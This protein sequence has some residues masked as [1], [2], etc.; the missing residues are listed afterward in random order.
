MLIKISKKIF[1]FI[2]I[3]ILMS[4]MISF[5]V[6]ALSIEVI[7]ADTDP[8]ATV[9]A[10]INTAIATGATT[11]TVTGSKITANS[12][13]NL[14]IPAGVT[15]VWNAVYKGTAN[16]VIDYYGEGTL[17]IS[18]PGGWV[19]NTSAPNSYSAIRANGS[20]IV[21]SGGIVQSGKGRAIEGAGPNTVVSVTGGSVFNEATSNLFPVIDMTNA[22]NI[23]KV[24]VNVSGGEV[25]A[26]SA[27]STA[28]G[29]VIQSYGNIAISG[30]KLSTSGGY[31]RVINLVGD[32]TNVTVSGGVLEA[33]GVAGTAISTST[34]APTQ[35]T[36][37]TVTIT[38]GFVAS[39]A[40]GNGWAIHTTGSNSTVSITG[41][42]VFAYG[43]R[44]S[45]SANS[46]IYTERNAGGFSNATVNGI[47]IAWDRPA[48]VSGGQG[49]YYASKTADIRTSPTGAGVT[50]VWGKRNP[51]INRPFDGINY[52]NNGNTGFVQL[53]EV[54]VVDEFYTVRVLITDGGTTIGNFITV[55]FDGT[56]Y[57]IEDPN[58]NQLI[59]NVPYNQ[60]LRFTVT[61][62]TGYIIT[63]VDTYEDITNA[64]Y[65]AQPLYAGN[66]VA[67]TQN[68]DITNIT[69]NIVFRA[70]FILPPPSQRNIIAFA[71]TGGNFDA[72]ISNQVP[73]NSNRTFTV[74]A[75]PGYRISGV[76]ADGIPVTLENVTDWPGTNDLHSGT[77]TFNTITLNHVITATFERMD[78]NITATAGTGG[79]ISPQ[80]TD[81]VP[82]GDSR[83]YTITPDEGYFIQE[84]LIDGLPVLTTEIQEFLE[85]KDD[86]TIAV[87]FAL[88]AKPDVYDL[89]V[90]SGIGGTVSGTQSGYYTLDHAVSATATANTGYRFTGW[91]ITGADITGGNNINPAEFLMPGNTVILTANFEAV[92]EVVRE[93]GSP[94]TGDSR[95]LTVPIIIL[96]LGAFLI[97][98]AEI[99]RRGLLK[100]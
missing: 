32:S 59:T 93:G 82:Y 99:Y 44:I 14:T 71:G 25:F 64:G 80:G 50:A 54:K 91:T 24:I 94:Q 7:I 19:Q 78:L 83:I 18:G 73:L 65:Y 92:S 11:V 49:L 53:Q 16:P 51:S 96:A 86:H 100:K 15:V 90:I 89:S 5:N 37:T 79:S 17:N 95:N 66:T 28:Y 77:Y 61:S 45:G 57:R 26:M 70:R 67:D 12:I 98:G 52:N 3:V 81:V 33:T 21:V 38:G 13:L 48:W 42:C 55:P 75:L 87:T 85:V 40:T 20:N 23:G 68:F 84:V 31:G 69:K 22:S 76:V 74:T 47:V 56:T 62:A 35:V 63:L 41:G 27:G 97:A 2:L 36:N 1:A 60:D 6:S 43:D 58:A 72:P 46:V 88:N 4:S 9:Q 29:Y 30:G 34:T 8:V 39:Y 10:L